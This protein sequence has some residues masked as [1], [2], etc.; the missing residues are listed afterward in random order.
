[1]RRR[2]AAILFCLAALVWCQ[3]TMAIGLCDGGAQA[4]AEASSGCHGGTGDQSDPGEPAC[5]VGS[6]LPD[7]AK[8]PAIAPLPQGHDFLRASADART[9]MATHEAAFAARDGP[10]L[11]E[12]CRLLI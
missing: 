10:R 2:A 3:L 4:V 11:S 7:L 5:P 1:M 6:A 12:L 9:P 8:L